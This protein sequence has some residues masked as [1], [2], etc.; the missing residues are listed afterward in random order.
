MTTQAFV[1]Y[2][3]VKKFLWTFTVIFCKFFPPENAFEND[4]RKSAS[5]TLVPLFI[6]ALWLL[7]SSKTELL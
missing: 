3:R 5:L 7:S 1:V 6:G 4:A 2:F